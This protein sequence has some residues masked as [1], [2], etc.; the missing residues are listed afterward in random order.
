MGKAGVDLSALAQTIADRVIR[1]LGSKEAPMKAWVKQDAKQV[2]KY[3]ASKASWY[4]E[5]K[6][7][8]TRKLRC[9]SCGPGVAG[10]RL[11]RK[12][13]ERINAEIVTGSYG[14]NL[15]K[16]W[17]DFRTDYEAKTVAGL[18]PLTK[19]AI[20]RA[21][22]VF[23]SIIGLTK[24]T[25]VNTAVIDT[26]K[27]ARRKEVSP[28]SVNKD[29]RHIKAALNK[30]KKWK[31]LKELPD[32]EF[33]R[34]ARKLPR[35]VTPQDFAAIYRVADHATFPRM[36]GILPGDWWRAVFVFAFMTG[37]RIGEILSLRRDDLDMATGE[38][39]TRA[40]NNKG[41]RDDRII[42]HP[43]ALVHIEKLPT[44]GENVFPWPHHR[45]TLF[46]ELKRLC[47]AA[48]VGPYGFHDFRRAFATMNAGR[49][50]ADALQSLMRHRSYETTKL[51]VNL[52]R[53]LKAA[54]ANLYVPELPAAVG[55]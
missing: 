26:F 40:E 35:Y 19:L 34:E 54:P 2:Q 49:V 33:E 27:A 18:S 13:A 51:Y 44:F 17:A 41:K 47:T 23:E 43:I 7:P 5:W 55:I 24:I 11:A 52:A 30:A 28:A 20:A 42:L 25:A 14:S 1:K 36:Q 4:V 46:H 21:L 16:S 37:W 48:K 32:F 12:E 39:T 50:T 9:K 45:R 10:K 31:Y 3:G 53:Q 15:N 29:L 22:D 38:A 8:D 6:E